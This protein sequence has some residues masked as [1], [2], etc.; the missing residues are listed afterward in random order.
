MSLSGININNYD[1]KKLLFSVGS[2]A[3]L[4]N[5]VIEYKD[6]VPYNLCIHDSEH[7]NKLMNEVQKEIDTTRLVDY[8]LDS[9]KVLNKILTP[10]KIDDLC[11]VIGEV[12]INAE[13]HSSTKCRYSIGYF[14]ESNDHGKHCGVFK[15]AILNFGKTIYEK[16]SDP[17]CPNQIVVSKMRQL[18]ENYTKNGFFKKDG[19]RP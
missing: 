7:N 1:V 17:D 9:L 2:A 13:E 16:F 12:L 10:E 18:S 14:Q 3:I 15:L 8:V 5:K 11:T 6:I 19:V 4:A